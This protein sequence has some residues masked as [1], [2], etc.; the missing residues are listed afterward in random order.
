[1]VYIDDFEGKELTSH[2][3]DLIWKFFP[4]VL[5]YSLQFSLVLIMLQWITLPS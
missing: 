3:F 1:M 4:L 5:E 2:C